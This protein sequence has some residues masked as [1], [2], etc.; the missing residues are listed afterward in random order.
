M[1]FKGVAKLQYADQIKENYLGSPSVLEQ[2]IGI[3]GY[4]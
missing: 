2:R 3:E 1:D 4:N